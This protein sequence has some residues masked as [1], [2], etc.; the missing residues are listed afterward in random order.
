MHLYLDP[1]GVKDLDWLTEL[2]PGTGSRS[3]TMRRLIADRVDLELRHL[4]GPV[5]NAP[6]R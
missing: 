6:V 5:R 2:L 4:R 1:V 3:R